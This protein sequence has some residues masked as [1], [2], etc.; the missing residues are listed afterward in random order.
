MAKAEKPL[1][2]YKVILVKTVSEFVLATDEKN[3][4]KITN[5]DVD[6]GDDF[7]E[8]DAT[9]SNISEVTDKKQ[10]PKEERYPWYGPEQ[11]KSSC[12]IEEKDLDTTPLSDYSVKE[13]FRKLNPKTKKK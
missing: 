13:V 11:P 10:L 3:A 4:K 2:L 9:I 8:V 6:Y 1:K 5:E 7:Y 12:D